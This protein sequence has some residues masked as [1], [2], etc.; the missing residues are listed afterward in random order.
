MDLPR[1]MDNP[2]SHG[3]G[4]LTT[5]AWI[6][7]LSL[8]SSAPYP[9]LHNPGSRFLWYFMYDKKRALRRERACHATGGKASL[10]ATLRIWTSDST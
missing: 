4:G 10:Q 8:R 3:Y 7:R 9:Q 1:L 2:S 5:V 6:S